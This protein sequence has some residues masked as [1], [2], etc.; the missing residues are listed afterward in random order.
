MV[1][2]GAVGLFLAASTR[3]ASACRRGVLVGAGVCRLFP[4]LFDGGGGWWGACCR[5]LGRCAL[6]VVLRVGLVPFLFGGLV[7][8][9][10]A[11]WL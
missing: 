5:V 9:V 11:G 2:P 10:W 7:W 4:P 1:G 8:R 3:S 6:V